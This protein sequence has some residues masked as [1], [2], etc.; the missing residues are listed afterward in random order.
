[1]SVTIAKVMLHTMNI[2]HIPEVGM[3]ASS[4]CIN[5]DVMLSLN[6]FSQTTIGMLGMMQSNIVMN[7][8]RSVTVKIFPL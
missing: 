8:E 4:L 2:S 5:I 1:M 3:K 6:A 7:S